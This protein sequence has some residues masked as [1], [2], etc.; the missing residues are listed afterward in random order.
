MGL[1]RSLFNFGGNEDFDGGKHYVGRPYYDSLPDRGRELEDFMAA[2]GSFI[3]P[4]TNATHLYY[5][6]KK[7]Y[8]KLPEDVLRYLVL[9]INSGAARDELPLAYLRDFVKENTSLSW[10]DF[11]LLYTWVWSDFVEHIPKRSVASWLLSS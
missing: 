7:V 9:Q 4:A 1:L 6:A 10:A 2:G 5:E 8:A 3:M 11:C